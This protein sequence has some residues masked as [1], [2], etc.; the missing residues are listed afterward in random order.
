MVIF[1]KIEHI[2]IWVSDLDLI[3]DFYLKY[4]G[5][6]SN[7]K[8]HNT[9]TG[10]TSYFLSF[11]GGA[12]I[13]IMGRPDIEEN[14]TSK[15]Q[16]GYAHI[17]I[18]LGSKEKVV[19][20]LK[21]KK[22]TVYYVLFAETD[23]P[24]YAKDRNIDFL[25]SAF[26]KKSV[27]VL[28]AAKAAKAGAGLVQMGAK[29]AAL[30][31]A[32]GLGE[33]AGVSA[34]KTAAEKA[35]AGAAQKAATKA[36]RDV[37]SK[38]ALAG[39]RTAQREL[40]MQEGARLVGG[41]LSPAKADEL[42]NFV[43][44]TVGVKGGEVV[45]PGLALRKIEN[46]KTS[47]Y[48][49]LEE[50]LTKSNLTFAKADV[51]DIIKSARQNYGLGA[52]L[53]DKNLKTLE[54]NISKRLTNADAKGIFKVK[55][56]L[57]NNIINWTRKEGAVDPVKEQIGKALRAEIDNRLTAAVP[58][59]KVIRNNL[60]KVYQSEELIGRAAQRE[61]RTPGGAIELGLTKA[62]EAAARIGS[63]GIATKPLGLASA[64]NT[65][66]GAL[67]LG[68]PT[69][70]STAGRQTA[71]GALGTAIQ[72]PQQ[73]ASS[74]EGMSQQ[75]ILAASGTE[76]PTTG[77]A[78]G[79]MG[80]MGQ[81]SQIDSYFQ[82]LVLQDLQQTG[83]KRLSAIKAAYDLLIKTD[84]IDKLKI[85]VEKKQIVYKD[86]IKVITKT[87]EVEKQSV[88]NLQGKEDCDKAK[89]IANEIFS[90]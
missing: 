79:T 56:E 59:S 28:E 32:K 37:F 51:N 27:D 53:A 48:Q 6:T 14:N 29:E 3:K 84:E 57:D 4:F 67:P 38:L 7:N 83:G 69:I 23:N 50:S 52:N 66:G 39:Q 88:A 60:S 8:Y 30:Q 76:L 81:S 11:E 20:K 87:V 77:M 42:Y 22:C 74:L 89:E 61:V 80:D 21:Q 41:T 73:P 43:T 82:G 68:A 19:N 35:I 33:S 70:L 58:N 86:R 17:A 71:R 44:K 46:F 13:E 9:K 62:R 55:T 31:T 24:K 16:F 36:P 64:I 90:N 78:G 12:R 85:D 34:G 72:T 15:S 1:M 5:A 10:F 18:S 26:D 65:M 75:D 40:G 45:K 2:A 47:L 63:S 25:A 49:P 54:S